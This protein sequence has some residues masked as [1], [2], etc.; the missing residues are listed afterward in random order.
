MVQYIQDI[1]GVSA[2][3]TG[4]LFGGITLT[5]VITGSIIG[6]KFLDYTIR[7]KHESSNEILMCSTSTYISMVFIALASIPAVALAFIKQL[8]FC[9]I[10]VI[11]LILL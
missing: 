6:G 10:L 4:I 11:G 7:K 2:A 1:F 5:T 9:V 3:N 8:P